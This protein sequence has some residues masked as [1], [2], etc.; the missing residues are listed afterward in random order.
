M[1]SVVSA[2]SRLDTAWRLSPSACLSEE[3]S[4]VLGPE[5]AVPA[6]VLSNNT[7]KPKDT[8]LVTT[9]NL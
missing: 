4:P 8:I 9:K 7:L 2:G 5:V 1:I 3:D 6:L